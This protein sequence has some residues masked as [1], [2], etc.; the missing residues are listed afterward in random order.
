MNLWHEFGPA[1]EQLMKNHTPRFVS[2]I[3]ERIDHR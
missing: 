1:I 3:E 2:R